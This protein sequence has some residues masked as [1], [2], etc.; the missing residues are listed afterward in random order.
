M[1]Q[2]FVPDV[3]LRHHHEND[4]ASVSIYLG[5]YMMN[6]EFVGFPRRLPSGKILH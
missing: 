3:N 1:L 6:G 2:G 4:V 5:R